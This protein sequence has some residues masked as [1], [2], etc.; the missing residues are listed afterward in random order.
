M[1]IH[2]IEAQHEAIGEVDCKGN[3]HKTIKQAKK[4]LWVYKGSL[5]DVGEAEISQELHNMILWILKKVGI[6]CQNRST[7]ARP[8]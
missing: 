6:H 1:V 3:L 7:H 4:D 2:Y 8:A 5:D